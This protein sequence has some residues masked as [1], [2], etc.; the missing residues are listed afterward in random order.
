VAAQIRAHQANLDAVENQK[1]PAA[2][3]Q[4]VVRQY[5][6]KTQAVIQKHLTSLQQVE[7][8]LQS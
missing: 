5:L 3:D 8:Q 4:Q 2:Q 1:L 6:E 7:A